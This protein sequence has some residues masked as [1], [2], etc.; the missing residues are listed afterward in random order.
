MRNLLS[1]LLV[2]LAAPF[3]CGWFSAG[4]AGSTPSDTPAP[5]GPTASSNP[6]ASGGSTPGANPTPGMPAPTFAPLPS[7]VG[8]QLVA[9]G[10]TAPVFLTTPDDGTGRRFVVDQVGVIYIL[11][12]DGTPQRPPF[13]DLRDRMVRLNP[14]Y[15]ERGALGLAFHPRFKENRR[16]IVYYSAPLRTGA[17]SGWNHTSHVAE[18]TVSADNPNQANPGSERII[19]QVDK[20]QANHNGGQIAFGPDGYLYIPIGDGGGANDAGLGHLP[21]GNAQS[22]A[23]FLGKILRIDVDGGEPYSVPPDNPFVAEAAAGED[24]RPEIWAYGLRNPF[25]ISFDAGGD[26]QLFT[27]DAG[28]NRWEEVDIIVKGGNY[29]WNIKEGRHCFDPTNPRRDAEGCPD[30]GARGEP[31]IDPII[32]YPNAAQPQ[33]VGAVVIG[34]YV[35]RGSAIPGLVGRYIFADWSAKGSDSGLL[36]AGTPLPSGSPPQAPWEMQELRIAGRPDGRIGAY[37]LS[38]GQD[39]EKEVYVLT[40]RN[41]GPAGNTGRAFKIVPAGS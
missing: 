17:P 32:E 40:S 38:F 26:H 3:G 13:L 39:A 24:V 6:P 23:T 20:P 7:S 9:E 14:N 35:Y 22:L 27:G 37:V 33:G 4:G 21:G 11:G 41:Q 8:L 1:V 25:E 28:Q 12:Q 30:T 2:L 29:G 19:L 15:D 10:L 31:L 34:G 5:A 36:F 18:F 16:F